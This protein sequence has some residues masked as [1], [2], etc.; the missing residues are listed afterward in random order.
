MLD[1]NIVE[2]QLL[3]FT[4]EGRGAMWRYFDTRTYRSGHFDR[5]YLTALME[6]VT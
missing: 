5:E 1:Q 2:E 4:L 3:F 6:E